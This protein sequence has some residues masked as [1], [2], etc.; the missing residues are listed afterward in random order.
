[1]PEAIVSVD[2]VGEL[3]TDARAVQYSKYGSVRAVTGPDAAQEEPGV[4][5]L[6]EAEDQVRCGETALLVVRQI[7]LLFE[8]DAAGR[9]ARRQGRA[10]LL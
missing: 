8:E 6:S 3:W 4:P 2:K 10:V 9:T 5:S 7:A 1:M